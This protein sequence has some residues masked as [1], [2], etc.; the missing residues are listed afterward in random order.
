[1]KS[2]SQNISF[3][4]NRLADK[5]VILSRSILDI[6]EQYDISNDSQLKTLK[7]MCED[8]QMLY[9]ER[10]LNLVRKSD[11]YQAGTFVKG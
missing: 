6:M 5:A 8:I 10:C 4:D 9:A 1:M 11:N 7:T 3:I 2:T